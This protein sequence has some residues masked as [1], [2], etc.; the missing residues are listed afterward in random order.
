M[1]PEN[2]AQPHVPLAYRRMLVEQS[3]AAMERA[4]RRGD[5]EGVDAA[6][7]DALRAYGSYLDGMDPEAADYRAAMVPVASLHIA[8]GNVERGLELVRDASMVS[9]DEEIVAALATVAEHLLDAGEVETASSFASEA[10]C[11]SSAPLRASG[12]RA[13][14]ADVLRR[15][16][17]TD[18][19]VVASALQGS[20]LN[21]RGRIEQ[22]VSDGVEDPDV[23]EE[24]YGDLY[25]ALGV[26]AH[27][28]QEAG[29]PDDARAARDE[30]QRV[31]ERPELGTDVGSERRGAAF[32]PVERAFDR[33][34]PLHDAIGGAG[35]VGD[36]DAAISRMYGFV[37]EAA[38]EEPDLA[39][40][41]LL[42]AEAARSAA[43]EVLRDAF[44]TESGHPLVESFADDAHD[45]AENEVTA[46][47][48]EALARA[49]PRAS[50]DAADVLVEAGEQVMVTAANLTTAMGSQSDLVRRWAREV[51]AVDER[52]GRTHGP[53]A[54]SAVLRA[55]GVPE[56]LTETTAHR[57]S[58]R[59][60]REVAADLAGAQGVP[61]VLRCMDELQDEATVLGGARVEP[62]WDRLRGNVAEALAEVPGTEDADASALRTR[63]LASYARAVVPRTDGPERG[64]A[65]A[66]DAWARLARDPDL[67]DAVV[68]VV[69]EVVQRMAERGEVADL[70][71]AEHRLRVIGEAR[72]QV[73]DRA[74]PGAAEVDALAEDLDDEAFRAGL[75]ACSM[76]RFATTP[77]AAV[78]VECRM[79]E[80]AA[81]VVAEVG[82]PDARRLGELVERSR[83]V[84]D[85]DVG[86]LAE[87]PRPAPGEGRLESDDRS[88]VLEAAIRGTPQRAALIGS[89]PAPVGPSM[90]SVGATEHDWDAAAVELLAELGPQGGTDELPQAPA[91]PDVTGEGED[92]ERPHGAARPTV[93]PLWD[94]EGGPASLEPGE[95]G[96]SDDLDD[97]A[98]DDPGLDL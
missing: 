53:S 62:L 19:G 15:A 35:I 26:L 88:M 17:R 74:G 30:A 14:M 24:M 21:L 7:R 52:L 80:V 36:F 89:L 37:L 92:I 46:L 51:V 97:P 32:G 65:R 39:R 3:C 33:G 81:R 64:D 67:G 87:E 73:A 13:K 29:A 77:V 78:L 42:A 91:D 16:A 43:T 38:R 20:V 1:D 56:D 82:G 93:E 71:G 79:P 27:A 4:R 31:L 90:A 66:I 76:N 59:W 63:A 41:A 85:G 6:A 58:E 94:E 95:P 49:L 84:L 25:A 11:R 18:P 54:L 34:E 86:A 83:A 2:E 98:D 70:A 40:D 69:A 47:Y 75:A 48:A 5:R 72:E 22:A 10:L 60:L 9:T 61:F 68:P 44:E 57:D 55:N 50:A 96:P 8:L 12:H 45:A 28:H 23:G